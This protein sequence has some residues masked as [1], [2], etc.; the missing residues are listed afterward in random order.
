MSQKSTAAG[1]ER[2]PHF[3]DLPHVLRARTAQHM[4][5]CLVHDIPGR[6]RLRPAGRWFSPPLAAKMLALFAAVAGQS[7]CSV[8]ARTGSVLILYTQPDIRRKVVAAFT[9]YARSGKAARRFFQETPA[10]GTTA[11]DCKTPENDGG[12]SVRNPIPGKI[13]S[14]LFFPRALRFAWAFVQTVPYL[15]KALGAL[16]R[17]RLDLDVLDG[18]A[19]LVCLLRRDFVSLGSIVFFFALGDFLSAWTRKKSRASLEE[20][21]SLDIS[22]V[23]IRKGGAEYEIPAANVQRDDEVVVR[24]GNLVPVDGMVVDGE[25]MVNQAFM[26]GEALPVPRRK[27]SSVYAGTVLAEGEIVVKATRVGAETR[28]KS[29]IRHIE[30]SEQVKASLQNKYERMADSIVPYNFLL[31]GLVFAVTGSLARAGSVLLVDYSCAIRLATPLAIFTGMRE[32]AEHGILIKGG[33]FM[34]ALAGADTVVFDK[35]GTLTEARPTLVAIVPFGACTHN[36]VLRL[37]ACLEEHFAH[38]VGQAV[39]RAAEEK[40]LKH[41]EEHAQVEYRLAHG[42]A[43]RWNGRRVLLGSDHFV[44]EDEGIPI[45]GEQRQEIERHARMGRSAL[46]LAVGGELAGVL[47][48]ED[49]LR[50][51]A[52]AAIV[53]L[54]ADGIRRIVMLTGDGETTARSIAAQAGITEY[55][56]RML[57]EHKAAFIDSLKKQGHTVLMVGDGIN[58]SPALSAADVGAAMAEGADL[59]REVADMVLLGGKLDDIVLARR[60]SRIA[61]GR[62]RSGFHASLLWNSLFLAGSLPGFLRPGFSALLHNAT[63]AAIA[64][65]AM[66]PMLPPAPVAESPIRALRETAS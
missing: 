23:W 65:S 44:L 21:L 45:S 32:A 26:T 46:Y 29:I 4:R 17:G 2:C 28:I 50:A 18:T 12:L 55:R 51:D 56:A 60:V 14:S 54:R 42:I 20:S 35:T 22:R 38:P 11:A 8:S 31:G 34:E 33:K 6:M 40:N 3:P 49:T 58:D 19:L 62:V 27:G 30:E 10:T 48:I 43:S 52:P 39:V 16:A 37:A 7:A 1:N 61:L 47:L 13:L 41:R 66:R 5:F 36:S 24:A 53:A 59:A 57:P 64:V 63:T 9:V 15:F 25:G